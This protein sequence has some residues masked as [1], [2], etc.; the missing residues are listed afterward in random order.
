MS[1]RT[2]WRPEPSLLKCP[3]EINLIGIS[4]SMH[5]GGG[6]ES[7]EKTFCMGGISYD[8]DEHVDS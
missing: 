2:L 8:Q 4:R 5:M 1:R 6:R 7:V 3:A